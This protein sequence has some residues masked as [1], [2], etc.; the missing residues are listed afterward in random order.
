MREP[1]P[2]KTTPADWQGFVSRPEFGFAAAT[3]AGFA[4]WAA[5]LV[6]LPADFVM[7]VVA[8]VFFIFAALFGLTAWL[9]RRVD[10]T[11]VTYADVAGALTLIGICAAAT[12]EPEQMVALVEGGRTDFKR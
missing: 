8:T 1:M 3:F 12:I 7:P 9:Q 11:R 10:L 5:C 2:S 6:H 4:A